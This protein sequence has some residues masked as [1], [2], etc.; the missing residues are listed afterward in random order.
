[1]T[2]ESEDPTDE[3]AKPIDRI[4][5]LVKQDSRFPVE[6]YLFIFEALKYTI[7]SIGVERHV[8]GQELCRGILDKAIDSFGPLAKC[9]F[10]QWGIRGTSDFGQIVY[11]LIELNL[12]GKTDTDRREDFDEVFDLE[13]S[14]S[15]MEL[16]VVLDG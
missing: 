16:C 9:V 13:A 14:L 2:E 1:M 11:N 15:D 12:M 6:A 8:T 4:R 5:R 10:Q 3:I 7:D